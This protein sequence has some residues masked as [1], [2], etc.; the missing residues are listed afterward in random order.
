MKSQQEF[1]KDMPIG[2]KMALGQD[3][4]AMSRFTALSPA[5]QQTFM[6]GAHQINSEQE[7]R[8]YVKKL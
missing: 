3:L 2:L 6:Q 4:Q 5:Q 7:M 8:A 1:D